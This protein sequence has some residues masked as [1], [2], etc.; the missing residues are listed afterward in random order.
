MRFFKAN[1]DKH[2]TDNELIERFVQSGDQKD[3]A[4]LYLRYAELIYGVCLFYLKDAQRAKDESL[5]LYQSLQE[6]LPHHQVRNFK[7]W[8]HVLTKNHCLALLRKAK[9][10]KNTISLDPSF[11]HLSASMHPMDEEEKYDAREVLLVECLD[12]LKVE[13]KKAIEGFYFEDM[14]YKQIAQS[15]GWKLNRV[16]SLIQNGRRN[17]KLCIEKKHEQYR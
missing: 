12:K 4:T 2:I 7:S 15:M 10:K 5:E 3:L 16:R 8:L 17:L 11:M 1:K 6:K 14:S 13:Q 9:H